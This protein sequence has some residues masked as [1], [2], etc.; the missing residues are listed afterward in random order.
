MFLDKKVIISA[1]GGFALGKTGH[2]IFASKKAKECYVKAAASALIVKDS[3][4]EQVENIQAEA[5]DI[6]A[7]ARIEADKYQAEKDAEYAASLNTAKTAEGHAAEEI[8]AV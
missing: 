7:D 6:M 3:I 8:P 1:L 5:S 2:L 4:M